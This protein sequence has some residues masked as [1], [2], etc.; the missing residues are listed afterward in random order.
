MRFSFGEKFL[1]SVRNDKHERTS[2]YELLSLFALPVVGA[3]SN[4]AGQGVRV[5]IQ[6]KRSC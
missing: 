4:G 2:I 6:S 1:D 5:S 3:K